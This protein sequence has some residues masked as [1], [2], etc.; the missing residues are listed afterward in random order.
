MNYVFLFPYL[1]GTIFWRGIM[2][3]LFDA[4]PDQV[5]E[6][7]GP[8]IV[9]LS[10]SSTC[11][12]RHDSAHS[13][14]STDK[15]REQNLKTPLLIE[16]ENGEESSQFYIIIFYKMFWNNLYVWYFIILF[17]KTWI[18]QQNDETITEIVAAR[19]LF[20]LCLF[21]F[22]F[23]L[24]HRWRAFSQGTM[25]TT[26]VFLIPRNLAVL[27]GFKWFLSVWFQNNR[28][29]PTFSHNRYILFYW[30]TSSFH[31]KYWLHNVQTDSIFFK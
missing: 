24:F 18:L 28:N 5:T 25:N 14:R 21:H 17:F 19:F 31:Y 7:G 12:P 22:R 1:L 9:C 4:G 23:Y 29:Y 20:D 27:D 2:M 15:R 3:K 6:G 16:R 30:K 13:I 8:H 26:G 10:R 11:L